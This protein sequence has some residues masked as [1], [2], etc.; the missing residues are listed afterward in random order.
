MRTLPLS[1]SGH[2]PLGPSAAH[3]WMECPASVWMEAELPEPPDSPAAMEGTLA[4]GEAERVLRG[5]QDFCIDFPEAQDYVDYVR[6]LGGDVLLVEVTLMWEQFVPEGYGTADAIVINEEE[7]V[8]EVCD[9]KFGRGVRV[10][11]EGNPQLKFYALG[12]LLLLGRL[13]RVDTYRVHIHQPRLDHIAV[14]EYTERDLVAFGE[15]IKKIYLHMITADELVPNPGEGQC[16]WCR[17]SGRCKQ[18][19]E[20]MMSIAQQE[21]SRV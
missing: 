7:R 5:E 11:A 15:K 16:R 18:Q 8:I 19:A 20:R 12:A 10:E 13:Y 14:V 6:E 2:H 3:R 9:L 17:A 21:F 1:E 4:H